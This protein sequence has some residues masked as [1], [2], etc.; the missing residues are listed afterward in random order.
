MT[1]QQESFNTAES[2]DQ[3]RARVLKAITTNGKTA[4]FDLVGL[5]NW[6]INRIS[7]RVTE[8]K[9][10]GLIVEVG[11]KINPDSGKRG[12]VYANIY[13]ARLCGGCKN[14][15]YFARHWDGREARCNHDGRSK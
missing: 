11:T 9:A 10:A 6:P 3:K 12:A 5:L 1:T 13:D 7:G 14:W 15:F 8:L 4:L 2:G